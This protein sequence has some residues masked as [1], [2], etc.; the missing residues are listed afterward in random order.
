MNAKSVD[1]KDSLRV[2]EGKD[3]VTSSRLWQYLVDLGMLFVLERGEME[4]RQTGWG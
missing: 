3:G 1:I 4:A 2:T